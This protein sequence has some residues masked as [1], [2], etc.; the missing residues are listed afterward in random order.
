MAVLGA[1]STATFLEKSLLEQFMSA[2]TA[3]RVQA[4]NA[5]VVVVL[6]AISATQ[7]QGAQTGR[8]YARDLVYTPVGKRGFDPNAPQVIIP[9]TAEERDRLRQVM[10]YLEG[11]AE[12]T[13]LQQHRWRH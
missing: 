3:K 11:D 9:E 10:P 8:L 12:L 7:S 2:E 4:V 1:L 6:G 5:V 13:E